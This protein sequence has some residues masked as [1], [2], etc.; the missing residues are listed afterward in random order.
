MSRHFIFTLLA[1]GSAGAFAQPGDLIPRSLLVDMAQD[2]YSVLC[3]SETFTQCMGF[4]S[5]LC[6]E[7]ADSAI[8]QC[9]LSLPETIDPEELDNSSLESCPVGVFDDAGFS[10]EKAGMCFNEAMEAEGS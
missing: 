2:Q 7:L 4:S 6:S 5:T 9:L 10:E 3:N 1:L 8:R